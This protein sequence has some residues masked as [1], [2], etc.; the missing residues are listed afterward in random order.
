MDFFLQENTALKYSE[1]LA[2]LKA[3]LVDQR[4]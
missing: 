1:E 2:E 3:A 4:V